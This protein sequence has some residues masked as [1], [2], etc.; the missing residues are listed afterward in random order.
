MLVNFGRHFID[1]EGLFRHNS[2]FVT[3][4][5]DPQIIKIDPFLGL[6][7]TKARNDGP[8]QLRVHRRT[9]ESVDSLSCF[10]LVKFLFLNVVNIVVVLED[11]CGHQRET[12]R[13][14]LWFL[15]FLIA[16]GAKLKEVI[17]LRWKV[18]RD[19]I[20]GFSVVEFLA[21]PWEH[22]GKLDLS[23]LIDEYIFR[24]N[25]SN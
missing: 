13:E 10:V 4:D 19:T 15:V 8:D 14:E 22:V 16:H 21:W 25:V 1:H 24:T 18:G 2:P 3:S 17:V 9:L 5:P 23:A 11:G 12:D 20:E 7:R 6:K